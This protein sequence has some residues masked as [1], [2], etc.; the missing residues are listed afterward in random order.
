[1]SREQLIVIY[2]QAL[3]DAKLA[4]DHDEEIRKQARE[5]D[6]RRRAADDAV[7]NARAAML[8]DIEKPP[9]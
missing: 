9:R 1:M 2:Q 8:E 7:A 3:R 5:S 6:A 4:G